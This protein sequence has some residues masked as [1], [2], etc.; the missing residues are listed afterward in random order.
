MQIY[1]GRNDII[2]PET[3][4]TVRVV[5]CNRVQKTNSDHRTLRR[6]GRVDWSLFY[7]ESGRLCFDRT[8]LTAG[9][10][11]ICPPQVPQKY[12][13]YAKDRTVYHY[14]HFTGSAVAE[15]LEELEI[16]TETAIDV[17]SLDIASLLERIRQTVGDAS[18]LS[19]LKGERCTLELFSEIAPRGHAL[20]DRPRLKQVT[21]EME[22]TF[23]EEYDAARYAAMLHLSTHRFNHFFKE[24]AGLSPYAYV[25]RLR[26]ANAKS[27]LEET[28][29]KVREIAALCGYSDPLYFTQAFK[30]Q[31]GKTPSEYRLS[32]R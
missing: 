22:H 21:D 32:P 31:T 13:T 9:Q 23:S 6:N 4:R 3:N 10:L 2:A 27:L 5:S 15:L 18:A 8:A 26:I 12:T 30:K 20:S 19:R 1:D 16:P 24:Q 14:L 17:Q 11:Y 29:L 7:C 28:A 25:T